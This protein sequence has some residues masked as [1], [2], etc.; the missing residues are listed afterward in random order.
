[1]AEI[2][3][4]SAGRYTF[5]PGTG[6]YFISVVS[7]R[8]ETALPPQKKIDSSTGDSAD[9]E[10]MFVPS[11]VTISGQPG[12]FVLFTTNPYMQATPPQV[13]GPIESVTTAIGL[14]GEQTVN[15]HS[16]TSWWMTCWD[17]TN[18][19]FLKQASQQLSPSILLAQQ[20]IGP[21]ACN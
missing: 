1:M 19:S 15:L 7:G 12:T 6:D 18:G 17:F 16:G 3:T 10:V 2:Q 21:V 14:N 20:N 5:N 11:R 9:F 13:P 8:N 4:D